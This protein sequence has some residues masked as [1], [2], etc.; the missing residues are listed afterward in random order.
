LK[1]HATTYTKNS[2]ASSI[3]DCTGYQRHGEVVGTLTTSTDSPKYDN[4]IYIS[5]GRTNY[6][7]SGTFKMPTD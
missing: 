6:G 4:C 3:M 5:D 7:K 1:N 2:R